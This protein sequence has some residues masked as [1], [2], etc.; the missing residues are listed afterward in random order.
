MGDMLVM[1]PEA[2]RE[3]HKTTFLPLNYIKNTKNYVLFRFQQEELHHI[4]NSDL[5]QGSTLVDI[6]SGPTVNFVLSATKK[7][8]DIV[9]S[10]LVESNRLEVDKWLKK[11]ADSVDWSFRAEQVAEL[12][13]HRDTKKGALEI[14]E[15]ARRAI[16]KVIP[17]DVLEPGVLPKEHKKPFDVV[18]SCNC[19]EAATADPESF[20]RVLANMGSL[21]KPGG[22]LVMVGTGGITWYE[23]GNKPLPM[24]VLTE[25]I[26][27]KAVTDAGFEI[28]RFRTG[29]YDGPIL[30]DR[31][32]R[33]GWAMV[34]RKS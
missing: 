1:K 14:M 18:L 11:S 23:V 34:A 27:R 10:D 19:L 13:G 33:F 21:V 28:V 12:E 20:G 30:E 3:V 6:G 32:K 22:F 25:E 29:E 31:G 16:S 4:F 8:R 24:M 17:C 9:V 26:I 5:I 7:F 15:R 2:L